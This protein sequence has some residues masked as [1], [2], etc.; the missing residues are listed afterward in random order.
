VLAVQS[1]RVQLFRNR[2]RRSQGEGN[3]RGNAQVG[4]LRRMLGYC[5]FDAQAVK[6]ASII[7]G[8][9]LL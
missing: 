6:N 1:R 7:Y 5:Y 4:A 8:S 3:D 9:S 2:K